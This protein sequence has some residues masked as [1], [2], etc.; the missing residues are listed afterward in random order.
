[1]NIRLQLLFCA[2]ALGT[3]GCAS[4]TDVVKQERRLA[5]EDYLAARVEAQ[6]DIESGQLA[7]EVY[8]FLLPYFSECEQLLCDRYRIH[9]RVVGGCVV[10]ESVRAHAKGYNEIMVPEIERR[11]GSNLWA[12]TE[13]DAKRIYDSK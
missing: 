13:A 10:D 6:R 4:S 8:G 7:Y 9:L 1:M 12:Q 5:R 3:F 2:L 11:F